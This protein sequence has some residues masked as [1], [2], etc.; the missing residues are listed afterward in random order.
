MTTRVDISTVLGIVVAF[1]L[2]IAAIMQSGGL[3]AF[4]DIPSILIVVLGTFAL[5]AAS[6]SFKDLGRALLLTSR[7]VVY[8]EESASRVA[9]HMLEI[10]EEARKNGVLVLQSKADSLPSASFQK[11]GLSMVVDGMDAPIVERVLSQD[12]HARLSRHAR[13]IAVLRKAADIAPAMGLIGTLI[14]LVQMLGNLN[15]PA[16]IGPAMAVALLTTMYGAVLA[17]LVFSPLATKLE[18]LS[19]NEVLV[20]QIYLKAIV[21]IAAKE[22][23]RRTE[24]ILNA[25]LPAA[26]R[27]TY[28]S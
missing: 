13:G 16:S 4:I 7:T 1:A 23:P 19:D 10:S 18:R 20:Q 5:V 22:N 9:L 3:S 15:D 28:F 6:F 25:I 17:F 21:A 2:I 8:P 27:I 26:Q 12:I 24:E 11:K 14:G